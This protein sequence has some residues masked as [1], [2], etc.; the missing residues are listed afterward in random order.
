A[1]A[2]HESYKPGDIVVIRDHINFMWDNP[3]RGLN[4]FV[5]LTEAYSGHLRD[6]AKTTADNLGIK[7][8]SGVYAALS[9]SSYETPA[10]IK[11][12]RRMGA[13]MV[14]MSTVPEVIMANSL[15]IKVLGLSMITN[16]ATGMGGKPLSHKEVIETSQNTSPKLTA[17]V[18]DLIKRI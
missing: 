1:G 3:L 5:D 12:L 18:K 8:R 17:L 15:G 11:A 10:E 13:D 14:G 9:G 4:R 6:L 7:L 16:M 2:V